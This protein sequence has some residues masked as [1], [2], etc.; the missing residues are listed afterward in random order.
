MRIAVDAMGGDNAPGEIIKGAIEAVKTGKGMI[1]IVLVGDENVLRKQMDSLD[2]R[3]PISVVH[4]PEIIDSHENPTEALKKQNSSISVAAKLQKEQ[5]VDAFVSAGNT[6]A[7]LA[8]SLLTLGKLGGVSRPALGTFFPTK[9]GST[10][11]LDVGANA[12]CKPVHLLEFGIMGY[13]CAKQIL[14]KEEPSVGLLNIGE[15]NTKGNKLA[16]EAY[17]LLRKAPIDSI[18]N[19]EGMDIVN[20]K[21]DVAV[22]DG[23]TGNIILKFGEGLINLIF[24][25]MRSYIGEDWQQILDVT[26]PKSSFSGFVKR[27]SHDEYGGVPLLGVNGIT[28]I[29]HGRS[30]DRAIYNAILMAKSS[31]EK[32]I[33]NLIQKNFN[34]LKRDRR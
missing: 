21:C 2:R 6:G 7:I 32:G 24:D 8:F 12:D 11:V 34:F 14:G 3:I 33:N 13:V 17:V 25:T 30:N 5:K 4:A 23:F 28:I 20:G 27:V 9:K 29:C 16:R 15:E 19:V 1:E 10:M 31:R 26:F 18:G 22:C